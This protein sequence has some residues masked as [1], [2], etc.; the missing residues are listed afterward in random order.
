MKHKIVKNREI[1]LYIVIFIVLLTANRFTPLCV[2]DFGYAFHCR[3]GEERIQF[4]KLFESA[5]CHSANGRIVV[6]FFIQLFLCM[7]KVIFDIINSVMFV[8]QIC[9]M[10]KLCSKEN[11]WIIALGCL[12]LVWCFTPAFGEDYLWLCAAVLYLWG[13]VLAYF[14]L[15]QFKR[16]MHDEKRLSIKRV[17]AASVLGF[18]CGVWGETT[19]VAAIIVPVLYFGVKRIFVNKSKSDICMGCPFLASLAGLI[20]LLT[21]PGEGIKM[22]ERTL[23]RYLTNFEVLVIRYIE[24]Y[25]PVLL[26]YVCIVIFAV[27]FLKYHRI[28]WKVIDFIDSIC[29]FLLSLAVSLSMLI[30][31]TYPLRVMLLTGG[32]LFISVLSFLNS[33][34]QKFEIQ[35]LKFMRLGG[36]I[37]AAALL[38]WICLG[39]KDICEYGMQINRIYRE[40]ES[41]VISGEKDI[42]IESCPDYSSRFICYYEAPYLSVDPDDYVN[43]YF[44]KYMN[45]EGKVRRRT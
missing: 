29:Y 41:A 12:G 15:Y 7:P 23:I 28:K 31:S 36:A 24:A 35:K 32:F 11:N 20:F 40:I 9:L 27:L 25:W 3:N 37:A 26:V 5:W 44:M 21:R 19:A 45:Y 38:F 42:V 18:V 17:A 16:W 13:G 22:G 39:M 8:G 4:A 34:N 6:C 30:T 33:F 1:I 43:L 2:D 10:K 14:Y